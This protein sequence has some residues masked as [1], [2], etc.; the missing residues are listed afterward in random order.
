MRQILSADIGG[1]NSRF[2]Q[3]VLEPGCSPRLVDLCSIPTASVASFGELMDRLRERRFSLL[4]AEAD[5]FVLAVAGPVR[6]GVYCQLTNAVW[7][8]DLTGAPAG[9]DPARTVLINDFVA[10]A[11]GC[12]TDKARHA[13]VIVQQG[14]DRDGV[15]A[16]VGAGTGLGHCA[17]MPAAD[18]S[19]RFVVIPSEGGHAPLGHGLDE[20]ELFA[21]VAGRTG[22]DVLYSEELVSGRGLSVV[23]EFL[24]GRRLH[25]S[26]V[27]AEI[28]P[29]SPTTELFARLYGRVCQ[30]YALYVLPRGGVNLCGG[31]AIKN[32]H[33]VTH[34]AFVHAFTQS[35]DYAY[36]LREIPVRLVIGEDT[37]LLGA[38]VWAELALS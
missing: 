16:T 6:D 24:T 8:I 34:P 38:A 23:H 12:I 25:P 35:A 20:Q 22:V 15:I 14:V 26:E 13:A 32:P 2:A 27:A 4:P 29:H 21:F 30:A 5:R 36:L 28:G 10:Q 11:F 19:G 7:N 9:V 18:G 3:I 37:G 17:L 1:T 33:L 31:L